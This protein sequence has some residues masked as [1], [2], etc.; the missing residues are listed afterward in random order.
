MF[1]SGARRVVVRALCLGLLAT[2]LPVPV[3]TLISTSVLDHSP[4][5]LVS[6]EVGSGTDSSGVGTV[7]PVGTDPAERQVAR[8]EST[9]SFAMIGVAVEHPD[10]GPVFVRTQLMGQWSDWKLLEFDEADGPDPGS[11]EALRSRSI[12]DGEWV[13]AATG[14]EINVADG[15]GAADVLLVRDRQTSVKFTPSQEP[16]GAEIDPT[17]NLRSVWGAR[18]PKQSA[19]FSSQLKL[20]IVHHSAS[21]NAYSPDDV[22]GILRSIQAYHMDGRGW[23][24]IAYNFVVDKFGRLWEGRGGG[25]DRLVLGGHSLGFNTSTVGVM[26][27]GEYTSTAPSPEAVD[28]VARVLGW[29]MF[30]EGVDPSSTNVPYTSGGSGT[31]PAG[32]VGSFNRIIGHRD[33]GTTECPGNVLYAQLPTIRAKAKAEYDR[34]TAQTTPFGV[35]D[36]RAGG[37]GSVSVSGWVIDPDAANG[38]GSVVLSLPD[39]SMTVSGTASRPDVGAAYPGF[40]A[41]HG[42]TATMFGVPAGQRSVCVNYPNPGPGRDTDLGCSTVTVAPPTAGSPVGEVSTIRSNGPGSV[43]VSGFVLDPDTSTPISAVVTVAGQSRTV[44]ANLAVGGLNSTYSRGDAHGFEATFSGVGGGSIS[45]CARAL[46]Q[47]SGTDLDVGCRS[48]TMPG[49]PPRGSLESAVWDGTN[50]VASGW[51][52]DPTAV[53]PTWV[54]LTIDGSARA[55]VLASGARPDIGVANPGYGDNHGFS[56]ATSNFSLAPG[57]HRVCAVGFD[58]DGGPSAELSNCRTI[59]VAAP[60]SSRVPKGGW[61][62]ARG[63]RRSV[64]LSGWG[65]DLGEPSAAVWVWIVVDKKWYFAPANQNRPWLSW[66]YPQHGDGHGYSTTIAASR[67]RHQVCA[68]SFTSDLKAI[69]I[70][71][72]ASVRST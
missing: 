52:I 67:G 33:V 62:G 14:Y 38:T 70:H 54:E 26:M 25:V 43:V 42:Y 55:G 17:I 8:E 41:N 13:K 34:L 69:A 3:L 49:G 22:P 50:V 9:D 56:V 27:L 44:V 29:K 37:P 32:T 20:G 5:Q 11:D 72:C 30:L 57:A 36:S 58:L 16:A 21:S 51:S 71:G 4:L 45:G 31:L 61:D 66:F 53:G 18:A 40:G 68:A 10:A 28:T 64:S 24:D 2:F 59:S 7:Q 47:G 48:V 19:S 23:N 6:A 15:A 12:S 60:P 35:A 1:P 63:G 46:N 65:I 39:R